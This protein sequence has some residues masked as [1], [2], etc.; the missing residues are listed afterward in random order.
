MSEALTVTTLRDL[1][2]EAKRISKRRNFTQSVEIYLVLDSKRVKKEEI[3]INEVIELPAKLNKP[4]K[5]CVIASGAL[6]LNAKKA[7]ADRVIEPDELDSLVTNRREARKIARGYDMFI[8]E[9]PLMP[10]IGRALGQFLGPRG[11]MPRPVPP[12]SDIT[13]IIQK[14]KNS[15]RVRSRGQLAVSCRIGDEKMKEEDLEKNA[16][17]VIEALERKI[18]NGRKGIK[19]IVVKLS[20]G[21]PVRAKLEEVGL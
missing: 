18:P 5:V 3:N 21:K 7:G 8:A 10:R 11:K 14:L 17:A 6:A 13:A 4:S 20:M 16:K 12:S 19:E 2:R 1:I 9:A 15:I